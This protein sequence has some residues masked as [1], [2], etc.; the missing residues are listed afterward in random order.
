MMRTWPC[1]TFHAEGEGQHQPRDEEL[2][3]G[4]VIIVSDVGG[5][6]GGELY[7]AKYED[8]EYGEEDTENRGRGV[9]HN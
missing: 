1:K 4:P 8:V 2:H 9:I 6:D 3:V 5:D 7:A